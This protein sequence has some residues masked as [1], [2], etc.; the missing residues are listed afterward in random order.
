LR[1]ERKCAEKKMK[2]RKKKRGTLLIFSHLSPI[3][4]S[5]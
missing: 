3:K 2:K 5:N 1:E 4:R